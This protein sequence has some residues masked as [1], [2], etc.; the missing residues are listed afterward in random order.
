LLRFA[1]ARRQVFVITW[2]TYAG[3]YFCRK[4]L[5]IV[6]PMLHEISQPGDL[7]QHRVAK[8]GASQRCIWL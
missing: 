7:V 6:L 1:A 8:L 3:F 4:N 2:I 5:G